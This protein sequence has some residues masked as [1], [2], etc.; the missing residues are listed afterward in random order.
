M[1]T[2]SNYKPIYNN[3][4]VQRNNIAFGNFNNAS[5]AAFAHPET[6]NLIVNGIASYFKDVDANIFSN[7][8]DKIHE[9]PEHI[10]NFLQEKRA[11]PQI[12]ANAEIMSSIR[13]DILFYLVRE[14]LKGLNIKPAS[15]LDIGAGNGK[16]TKKIA[17]LLKTPFEN[18]NALEIY[19]DKNHSE[20]PFKTTIYNGNNLNE[21]VKN[22]K[23]DAVSFIGSLHHSQNPEELINQS[24]KTLNPDGYLILQE[25]NNTTNSDKLFHTFM[26][27]FEYKVVE[28]LDDFQMTH[29]YRTKNEWTGMIEK[30]GFKTL[31]IIDQDWDNPF[32][33]FIGV[34][35]KVSQ[36]KIVESYKAL[37]LNTL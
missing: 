12:K 13:T 37:K 4:Y 26:D 35:Q 34:F 24:H 31:K 1:L 5:K 15:Y 3:H 36:D 23:Y 30:A 19:H 6:K 16:V 8:L 28:G 22:N 32:Q 27:E 17:E 11:F 25:H 2:Q 10:R 14:S 18:V 29:N 21:A 7:F 20:L 9:K 33:R